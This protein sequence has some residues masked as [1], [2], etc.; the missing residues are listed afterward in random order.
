MIVLT[1][2]LSFFGGLI[3]GS[4]LNALLWRLP[5]G[6]GMGGR[7]HCRSCNHVLAWYDLIPIISFVLLRAKCRYCHGT[8]HIRYPLVELATGLMVGLFF[9]TQTPIANIETVLSVFGILIFVSLFFFDLFYFILPDVI[10]FPAIIIYGLYDFLMTPHFLTF[11]LTALLLSAFF[12]ILY[13]ASRGKKLGLG[14]VKIA[15]LIGL[16]LG[17]PLGALS[18]IFGVWLAT[19][20]ALVLLLLK[21][22]GMKDAIP[23]GSFLA[24]STLLCLIFQNEILS[25]TKLFI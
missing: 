2:I 3:Y 19:F 14:D 21:K 17:Y 25:I 18:I 15:I 22:V 6:R 23:L 8:I 10:I 5:E 9:A 16:V 24:F 20:V 12:A 13:L 11:V 4:F 1:T 7:S